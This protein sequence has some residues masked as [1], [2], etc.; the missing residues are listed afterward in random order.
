M[1]NEKI[2]NL[3]GSDGNYVYPVTTGRAVLMEGDKD[4]DTVFQEKTSALQE[5][6][7]ALQEDYAAKKSELAEDYSQRLSNIT[8]VYQDKMNAME[9]WKNDF[10]A[11]WNAGTLRTV[12]LDQISTNKEAVFVLPAP[13]VIG[14][15]FVSRVGMSVKTTASANL[16]TIKVG[17]RM[18][19]EGTYL[20][21]ADASAAFLNTWGSEGSSLGEPYGD[22]AVGIQAGIHAGGE[23]FYGNQNLAMKKGS[24]V[25]SE[26]TL[27][28]LKVS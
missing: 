13:E 11:E 22:A 26:M 8:Q 24:E 1:A 23:V 7:N 25:A 4:L 5:K 28:W 18:P 9:T 3:K 6:A 2:V 10:L 14:R 16:S 21:L 12:T 15:V 19:A 17:I 20:L 27:V